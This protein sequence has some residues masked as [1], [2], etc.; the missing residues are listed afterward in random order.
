MNFIDD[1]KLNWEQV[2][3]NLKDYIKNYTFNY[4]NYN[5]IYKDIKL[6]KDF[7]YDIMHN[8]LV[9]YKADPKIENKIR[10]LCKYVIGT[11][12]PF[13]NKKLD[14]LDSLLKQNATIETANTM[15]QFLELEDDLYALASFRSLIHFA[16]YMERQDDKSQLVW[17]YNMNDTMGSIFYYSNKMILDH[18]YH[19][20]LKQCPTGYG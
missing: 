14:E 2:Y 4:N 20:L 5:E 15:N 18:E 17:K 3:I 13:I 11:L 9:L 16:H 6:I 19:N 8:K 10:E 12:L 7:I 1:G